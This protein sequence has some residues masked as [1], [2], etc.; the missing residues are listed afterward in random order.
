M[1]EAERIRFR[2]GINLGD[3]IHEATATSTA[4]G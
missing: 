1:P 2:I 4:T 3:V